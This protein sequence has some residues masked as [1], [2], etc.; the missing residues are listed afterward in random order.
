MYLYGNSVENA[1]FATNRDGQPQRLAGVHKS[2]TKV[3]YFVLPKNSCFK[4][5]YYV[6][7]NY[8]LCSTLCAFS[9][10]QKVTKSTFI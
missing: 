5:D 4:F 7:D 3:I 9:E 10:Q 6:V 2:D 1:K 8:M